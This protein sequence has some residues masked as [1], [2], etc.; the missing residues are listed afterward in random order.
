MNDTGTAV[1]CI[2]FGLA[3]VDEQKMR[4]ASHSTR[5]HRLLLE[6]PN[7]RALAS[8]VSRS[9][10]RHSARDLLIHDLQRSPLAHVY[11][12]GAAIAHPASASLTSIAALT[13]RATSVSMHIEQAEA[14]RAAAAARAL[15]VPLASHAEARALERGAHIEL[16]DREWAAQ[17]EDVARRAFQPNLI[18]WEE[19]RPQVRPRATATRTTTRERLE[20]RV[21][22]DAHPRVYESGLNQHADDRLPDQSCVVLGGTPPTGLFMDPALHF[23][24]SSRHSSA[25]TGTQAR[26]S[27]QRRNTG[28]YCT[29]HSLLKY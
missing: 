20:L 23:S 1:G 15:S 2:L 6:P 5:S 13:S 27:P 10:P 12:R 9:S 18:A 11:H 26:T 8:S 22:R 7:A 29:M 4:A 21:A 24:I 28:T 16:R 25:F 3:R 14:Q 19:D 17:R